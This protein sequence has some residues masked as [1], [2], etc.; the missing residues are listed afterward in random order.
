MGFSCSN[1]E[2][3]PISILLPKLSLPVCWFFVKQF[4]G[5]G[6][7]YKSQPVMKTKMKTGSIMNVTIRLLVNTSPKI[8]YGGFRI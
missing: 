1:S 5:A 4:F 2:I 8:S 6:D 3:N 7:V